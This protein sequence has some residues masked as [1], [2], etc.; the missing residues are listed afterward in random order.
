MNNAFDMFKNY[1]S[2]VAKLTGQLYS[3]FEYRT[4]DNL[5][6]SIFTK[7][8][9]TLQELESNAEN[10][11]D[12]AFYRAEK[13][14]LHSVLTLVTDLMVQNAFKSSEE[15]EKRGTD[16]EKLLDLSLNKAMGEI[17]NNYIPEEDGA[18]EQ[19][20]DTIIDEALNERDTSAGVVPPGAIDDEDHV[21]EEYTASV[22]AFV[23]DEEDK[24]EPAD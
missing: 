11:E 7:H 8:V 12:A 19:A 10:A 21:P 16:M 17:A 2:R 14:K 15:I 20:S 24:A 22:A 5:R 3:I 18:Y 9:K 4:R 23:G 6:E 1:C 13:L